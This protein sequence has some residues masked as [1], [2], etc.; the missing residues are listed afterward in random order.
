MNRVRSVVQA[1]ASVQRRAS[2]PVQA[3]APVSMQQRIGNAAATALPHISQSA[4]AWAAQTRLAISSPGDSAER[5]AEAIGRQVA[6]MPSPQSSATAS[7]TAAKH[8]AGSAPTTLARR[9]LVRVNSGTASAATALL[10]QAAPRLQRQTRADGSP[11][12]ASREV[13]REIAAEQQAGEALPGK[14]KQFM[15]PRFGADFARVKIHTDARAAK[16]ANQVQAQAFTV[17]EHIFFAAGQFNPDTDEGR[18]LL[19]HELTHTIQQGGARQSASSSAPRGSATMLERPTTSAALAALAPTSATQASARLPSTLARTPTVRMNAAQTIQRW[20]LP[21]IQTVLD[22]FADK[23]RYIPGYT[24]LTVIL[25]FNPISGRTV[26]RSGVNILR[27]LV[28]CIPAGPLLVQVLEANG[29]LQR[30]GAVA[31]REFGRLTGAVS[32]LSSAFSRFIDSLGA[33]DLLSPSGV[34]DR[35]KRM[36]TEPIERLIAA[37]TTLVGVILELVKQAVLQPLARL[38]QSTRAWDLLCAV[39]ARNPITGEAVPRNAQT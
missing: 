23:A 17:G 28:E 29:L 3:P 32:D 39:L 5:E 16:L 30:G 25:A 24:L 8:V 12:H 4:P 18:E 15:E 34:W 27:A 19:A 10:R 21:G 1:R 20:G 2:A 36:F 11:T 22:F 14:V 38:A 26:E 33:R 37:G 13:S 7:D 9:P 6:R 35:A 31:E